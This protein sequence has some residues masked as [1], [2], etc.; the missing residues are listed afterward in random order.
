M[1]EPATAVRPRLPG[2]DDENPAGRR[3]LQRFRLFASIFLVYLGYAVDGL[4]HAGLERQLTA[5]VL[6]VAFVGLY[7]GPL[8]RAIFLG[9]R[10]YRIPVLLAMAAVMGA[11]LL[12]VGPGGL[13]FA[14]YL[15]ISI[16]TALPPAA[17][18]PLVLALCAGTTF[19]PAQVV[20]WHLVGQQWAVSGP[21][22]LTAVAMYAVRNGSRSNR[23]LYLARREVERLAAE[24]ERLRIARD[25]H[26]LLGHA[27][28]TV[29]VKAELAS[30]LVERDPKRAAAEMLEAAELSRRGLADVRAA[31]AGYREV[32]LVTELA[33]AREVLRAAGISAELPAAVE[34]GPA[35]LRELFGWVV[36]EGVTNAVRHSRARHLSVLVQGRTIEVVDD[37]SG[38]GDGGAGG[39]GLRGLTERAAA[40]GG[41]VTA[42]PVEPTGFRLR[43]EVPA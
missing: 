41:R 27:L 8:P 13:I 12:L 36:R 15:S 3:G 23:E 2:D 22:L 24:Q 20:G 21:T 10:P 26:D 29:T 32:S 35:D 4:Q 43:V 40:S 11:Y 31:L 39:T 16:V 34:Q 5:A 6:L 17:S 1:P 37:G 28:T 19:L 33:T 9:G 7:L 25:L 38:P 18:A 30:R 14:T 42:G